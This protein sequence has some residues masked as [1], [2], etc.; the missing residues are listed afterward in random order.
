MPSFSRSFSFSAI[1]GLHHPLW[2]AAAGSPHSH[3]EV[4]LTWAGGNECRRVWCVPAGSQCRQPISRSCSMARLT[5]WFCENTGDFRLKT[6]PQTRQQYRRRIP[7]QTLYKGYRACADS[8][9]FRALMALSCS[10]F[11]LKLV[12][13]KQAWIGLQLDDILFRI[14]VS[15]L[16]QMMYSLVCFSVVRE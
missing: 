16:H 7:W 6:G 2:L 5:V 15:R 12:E 9:R 1:S 14:I 11:R 3:H 10:T 4:A 8:R 13:L